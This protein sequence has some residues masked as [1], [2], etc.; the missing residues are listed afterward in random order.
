MREPSD[1]LASNR[2]WAERT[3]ADA[4]GFFERLA[5]Q[6]APRFLWIGC[7]DS[8]VPANVI[9][10]LDPGEVFVHRNVANVLPHTDLNALTAL[11]YAVSVLQVEH[12]IVCGHYGCGG[13]LAALDGREHGLIDNWLRH[14]K[15]VAAKHDRSLDA[16]PPERR[17]DRLAELNAVE[18]AR[19]VCSTSIV[20]GAWARGQ[21]LTVRAWI[22]GLSDGLLRD[23]RFVVHG[24]EELAPAYRLSLSET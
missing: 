7:A 19:N 17:A 18:Q 4:P 12:V 1:L 14:I 11:D 10:G 16:L 6:Q 9:T 2:S 24:P 5:T 21:A 3:A 22:Y 15:D 8:R 23:L 13:I 20:Q